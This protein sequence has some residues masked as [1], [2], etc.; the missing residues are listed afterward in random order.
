MPEVLPPLGRAITHG[1]GGWHDPV[2]RLGAAVIQEQL[3]FA[4]GVADGADGVRQGAD[5]VRRD[6]C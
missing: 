3:I 1:S 5:G 2:E 6:H 4:E